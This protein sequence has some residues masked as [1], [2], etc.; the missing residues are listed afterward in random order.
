MVKARI[1]LLAV[2]ILVKPLSSSS[3][4]AFQELYF[5][6]VKFGD[7]YVRDGS[8]AI[9]IT[10]YGDVASYAVAGDFLVVEREGKSRR[11]IQLSLKDGATQEV[12]SLRLLGASCGGVTAHFQG[13][14]AVYVPYTQ[15]ISLL[16]DERKVRCSSNKDVRV[17]YFGEGKQ[18]K[19]FGWTPPGIQ[20]IED[21]YL[22][23]FAVSH[24]G[25]YLAVVTLNVCRHHSNGGMVCAQWPGTL[26]D[27]PAL[28]NDGKILVSGGT[29]KACEYFSATRYSPV[30]GRRA[31][32]EGV[33]ECL[34]IVR[35]DAE[36]KKGTLLE[37]LGRLPQWLEQS[38][39]RALVRWSSK[40][41]K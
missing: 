32:R 2:A 36:L 9:R 18:L 40:M 7:V 41:A 14:Q 16:S 21:L 35:F 34:G 19:I 33:D 3:S 1:C 10:R 13:R 6:F 4:G 38:E 12:E 29:G 25:S 31:Q 22:R 20:A 8:K 27:D 24:N 30:E 26:T 37:E 39:A 28:S 23:D 17:E 15:S 11:T 5:A